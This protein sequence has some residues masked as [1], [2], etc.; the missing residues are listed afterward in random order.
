MKF[1]FFLQKGAT[2]EDVETRIGILKELFSE[3]KLAAEHVQSTL[4]AGVFTTEFLSPKYEG[5]L[6]DFHRRLPDYQTFFVSLSS[7]LKSP[8][9]LPAR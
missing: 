7:L 6:D 4:E 5:C 9:K 3:D 8:K 2:P 1:L